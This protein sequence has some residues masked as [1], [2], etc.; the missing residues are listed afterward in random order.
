M[1]SYFGKGGTDIVFKIQKKSLRLIR[2]VNNRVSC[3]SMFGKFKILTVTSIYIFE[4]LCFI[5]KNK[6]YSTQYSDI[7]SYNTI[8][9]HNFYV[10]L[11]N[12]ARCKKCN[13]HGNKNI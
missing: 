5:I 1:A 4:I 11:C 9:K 8:H 10:Q 3:R 12:T 2:G 6:I 13:K 7:H